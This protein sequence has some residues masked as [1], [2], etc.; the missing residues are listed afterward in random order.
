[1]F[2]VAA[3]SDFRSLVRQPKPAMHWDRI[4][5]A[6]ETAG[7]QTCRVLVEE[8]F[9]EREWSAFSTTALSQGVCHIPRLSAQPSQTAWR[10]PNEGQARM[11]CALINK[12]LTSSHWLFPALPAALVCREAAIIVCLVPLDWHKKE[13]R[14]APF[15]KSFSEVFLESIIHPRICALKHPKIKCTNLNI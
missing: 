4:Y 9:L 5:P 10:C 8:A 14:E 13:T 11:L 1:M 6:W 7:D 3:G 12:K 2:F 15:A